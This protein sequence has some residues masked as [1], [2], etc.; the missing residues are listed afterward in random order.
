MIE[1]KFPRI[2]RD[3]RRVQLSRGGVEVAPMGIS[4]EMQTS[5][6]LAEARD[7]GAIKVPLTDDV[8]VKIDRAASLKNNLKSMVR[9]ERSVLSR[10]ADGMDV[11]RHG[12]MALL[13]R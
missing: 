7:L 3:G 11:L 10:V 5:F 9:A 6:K 4:P 12:S 1:T 13:G 2:T 8:Y